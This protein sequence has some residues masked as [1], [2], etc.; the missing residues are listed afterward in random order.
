MSPVRISDALRAVV[1]EPTRDLTDA[2]DEF[3]APDYTHRS[4][5]ETLDRAGFVE[6]VTR[7]RG[8][9]VSGTVQVL[10]ELRDGLDYAERHVYEITLVDGSTARREITIFGTY[11]EDGRFRHLSETGFDLPA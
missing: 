6:M 2:L 10:D 1:F 8:Q 7:V 11:A 9:I 4:D 3:Y 5:G